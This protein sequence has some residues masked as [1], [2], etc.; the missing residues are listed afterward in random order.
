MTLVETTDTLLIKA[1]QPS[2]TVEGRPADAA[3]RQSTMKT[4]KF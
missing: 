2:F 3:T 4:Y 1:S